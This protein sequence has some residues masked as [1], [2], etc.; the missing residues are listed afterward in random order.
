[1]GHSFT[2]IEACN[3]VRGFPAESVAI[4][5]QPAELTHD[6]RPTTFSDAFD[7]IE[8]SF[9]YQLLLCIGENPIGELLRERAPIQ[10]ANRTVAQIVESLDG[11]KKMV[12]EVMDTLRDQFGHLQMGLDNPLCDA[13]QCKAHMKLAALHTASD[14]LVV[15]M[16]Q[17]ESWVYR[18]LVL[19]K[20][21]TPER[22]VQV[23]APDLLLLNR[24]T[25]V[26]KGL[27]Q[28]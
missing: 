18:T 7:A 13:D 10:T 2:T 14:H 19:G 17:I 26:L 12:F 15:T 3:R 22:I 6:D 24:D 4:G 11:A 21:L 20:P 23:C 28:P 8:Q 25:A 9:G 5:V 27:M 16:H 1:M